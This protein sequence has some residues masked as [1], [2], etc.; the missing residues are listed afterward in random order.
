MNGNLTH[1]HRHRYATPNDKMVLKHCPHTETCHWWQ[2][3]AVVPFHAKVLHVRMG[4][5]HPIPWM[6][7]ATLTERYVSA[8]PSITFLVLLPSQC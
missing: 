8:R 6:S 5:Q 1:I 7:A 4:A 2:I 3:I